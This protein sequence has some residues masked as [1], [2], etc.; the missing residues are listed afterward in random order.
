MLRTAGLTK[1]FGGLTAV[2]SVDFQLRDGELCSLI[3]PNGAG[4]TTFFDLLTGALEPTAGSIELRRDGEWEPLTDA[5]PAEVAQAGVHR[6][7]Q[8][9]NVFPER[10]VLENVRVA[11]Q[12]AGPN[13]WKGWRNAAAFEEHVEEAYRI[14]DRVGLDAL[15]DRP[16]S[17]LSHGEK[18][19]LEVGIALAGDPD[20]LLLDEPNAGVSSES[21]D[22]IIDLIVD[23]ARDHAVLLVEHNMDIVM[24][25][26][27][28]I[29]VLNQGAVIADDEPEAVQDDPAVQRAYLGGYG[30]DGRE[31]PTTSGA[32]TGDSADDGTDAGEGAEP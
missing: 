22:D 11:A 5:S 23:V 15:A 27:D 2:D 3:G 29:V 21:V 16:A 18:R 6:S 10:T 7:Y 25:V 9:T 1:R 26:S 32:T 30:E 14:L 8:I 17:A 24:N 4:K 31:A 20:V 28:R 13:D 12:A 19:Q